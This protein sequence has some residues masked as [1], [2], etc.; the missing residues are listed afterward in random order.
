MAPVSCMS[1]QR[2]LRFARAL[3]QQSACELVVM[4]VM[5]T[6]P[7]RWLSFASHL[8]AGAVVHIVEV[9]HA[10]RQRHLPVCNARHGILRHTLGDDL[11]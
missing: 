1:G 2:L 11:H 8:A 10:V 5:A 4:L 9:H 3:S 6:K 7:M